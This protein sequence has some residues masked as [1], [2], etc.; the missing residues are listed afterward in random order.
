MTRSE[1]ILSY[2]RQTDESLSRTV[3]DKSVATSVSDRKLAPLATGAEL[4]SWVAENQ[5][6][7]ASYLDWRSANIPVA[8]PD[9]LSPLLT[10]AE[11]TSF[12]LLRDSVFR[13]WEYLRAGS[14][15]FEI[16][17]LVPPSDILAGLIEFATRLSRQR[18]EL[19]LG[20]DVGLRTVADAEWDIAIG[21]LHPF[22]D[23]CG[24]IAR[25]FSTLLC[26]WFDLPL[27]VRG[28]RDAYFKHAVAGKVEF[29]RYFLSC[30]RIAL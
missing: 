15:Q 14:I 24:R 29:A 17:E 22:Y 8:E 28:D 21:P 7:V 20:P 10:L 30:E 19:G 11:L 6:L 3:R 23:G 4:K 2:L 16:H 25:Y 12:R 18:K 5:K 9:F 13:Q 26:L 1:A 27:V